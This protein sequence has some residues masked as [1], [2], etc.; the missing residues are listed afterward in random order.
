MNFHETVR[1]QRFFEHQLSQLIS[2]LQ[3]IAT[4]LKAPR[5]VV[6]VDIATDTQNLLTQL[7]Y[8][9]FDPET[10]PDRETHALYNSAISQMQDD[11]RSSVDAEMWQ[12]IEHTYTTIATR[13]ADEREQAYAAGFRTAISMLACGLTASVPG[14][15]K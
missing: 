6:Q 8:T 14:G 12:M 11:I 1:G 13:T 2:A 10:A 7:Y 3:D 15:E 5:P 4:S 9:T